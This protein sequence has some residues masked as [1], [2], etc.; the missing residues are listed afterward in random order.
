MEHVIPGEAAEIV[1]IRGAPD[2]VVAGATLE[3]AE[4]RASIRLT[5]LAADG[6]DAPAAALLA[7]GDRELRTCR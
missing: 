7:G 3:A 1:E 2:D 6:V 4:V 5:T